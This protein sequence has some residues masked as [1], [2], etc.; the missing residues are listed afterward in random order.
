MYKN[1]RFI[2]FRFLYIS[3][4]LVILDQII[5]F[6]IKNLS[7]INIVFFNGLIKIL[8]CKNYGA[9]FGILHDSKW[10][11]VS[12][13]S[14][15]IIVLTYIICAKETTSAM[16]KIGV[17]LIIGGGISNLIDR[18]FFGYV[19]D[20]IQILFFQPICNLADYAI[21]FGCT[22]IFLYILTNKNVKQ[23]A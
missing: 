4:F 19:V 2:N 14:T 18:L 21:T 13:S 15:V 23:A 17:A 22:L 10:L 9:A 6:K 11:L 12:A 7:N 5:K 8:N 3:L 1:F 20:Y 16:F